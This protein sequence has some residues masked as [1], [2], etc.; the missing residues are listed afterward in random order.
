MVTGVHAAKAA[1]L[2]APAAVGHTFITVVVAAPLAVAPAVLV[3]GVAAVVTGLTVPVLKRYVGRIGVVGPQD[4]SHDQEEVADLAPFQRRSEHCSGVAGTQPVIADMGM[5][6]MI[7]A[8]RGIRIDS[9][10]IEWLSLALDS[11]LPQVQADVEGAEIDAFE[12]DRLGLHGE[13]PPDGLVVPSAELDLELVQFTNQVVDD[14]DGI[15]T[16]CDGLA[17]RFKCVPSV[18]QQI[19]CPQLES[20]DGTDVATLASTC[21]LMTQLLVL[22]HLLAQCLDPIDLV[23]LVVPTH[24]DQL[25]TDQRGDVEPFVIHGQHSFQK[26]KGRRSHIARQ[27]P[28]VGDWLDRT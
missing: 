28:L 21:H 18:A 8:G 26:R 20:T 10:A 22:G 2:I 1:G 3:H 19:A 16:V 6:D 24:L 12:F 23:G 25:I 4:L 14:R 11:E 17:G 13:R 5:G 9:D 7:G 15:G 27:T